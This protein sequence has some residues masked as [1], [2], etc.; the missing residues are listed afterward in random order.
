METRR[1]EV[2]AAGFLYSG[3]ADEERSFV[4]EGLRLEWVEQ[5][6]HLLQQFA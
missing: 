6:R 1:S 5:C 4:V 2:T 3:E